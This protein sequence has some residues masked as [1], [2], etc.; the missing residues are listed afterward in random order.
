[1]EKPGVHH[2]GEKEFEVLF[3]EHFDN[4]M[5]F[6]CSYVHDNEVARDLVHDAYMAIWSNRMRLDASRPLTS[7]LFVLARNYALDWIRHRKVELGNEEAIARM[8]EEG[9]GEVDYIY[10]DQLVRSVRLLLLGNMEIPVALNDKVLEL[11]VEEVGFT[12]LPYSDLWLSVYVDVLEARQLVKPTLKDYVYRVATYFRN[13][14]LREYY[15]LSQMKGGTRG[16]NTIFFRELFEP[17]RT[18]MVSEEGKKKYENWMAQAGRTEAANHFDGQPALELSFRDYEGKERR[19]SDYRGKF[20][21]IDFWATWCGP[22]KQETPYFSSWLKGRNIV[23]LSLSVDRKDSEQAWKKYVDE[24]GLREYCEVGWTGSGFSNVFVEHYGINA[25]P[26]FMLVG[27]DGE[28]I[29]HD[30]WRP[31][32]VQIDK[33]LNLYLK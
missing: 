5:G 2:I 26:R 7:Y 1:M 10:W 22:C 27:P 19:L 24:H 31:S 33:L 14:E 20:V 15:V 32:N 16:R 8:M 13:P 30:C 6:V 9:T 25:I 17:C 3:R 21:Y 28:M 11:P 23:C 18:L 29:H 12:K 4:L